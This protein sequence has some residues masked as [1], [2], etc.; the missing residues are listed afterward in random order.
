MMLE[1]A[2]QDGV[3]GSKKQKKAD[4]NLAVDIDDCSDHINLG[5]GID[6]RESLALGNT[7]GTDWVTT[8]ILDDL[9]FV[10]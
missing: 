1:A 5:Q 10:V 2:Q 3:S 9:P 4:S 6:L 7:V 8:L